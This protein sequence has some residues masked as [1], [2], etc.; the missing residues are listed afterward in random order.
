MAEVQHRTLFQVVH[1]L[2]GLIDSQLAN[3]RFWLKTEI[4]HIGS[5]SGHYYLDL[6]EH[7]DGKIIAQCSARIW[8]YSIQY[9]KQSLGEDFDNILKKGAEI[10]IYVDV[11][12]DEVYGLQ[13]VISDVDKSYALGA[14][15]KRKIETYER[16]KAEG[17]LEFNKRHKQPIVIQK[18]AVI[19][20]P[21]TSGHTDFIKQLKENEFRYL[22]QVE[23]YPCAVQ[24]EKAEGEIIEQLNKID[25]SKY[26]VV[27]VVRGGGSKLDLEVFN[28]Y[29]IAKV[30]ANYP[31]PVLTGIGHET[32][33]SIADLVA[34][35][36]YK[37]PSAVGAYIVAKSREYDVK[38]QTLY[39]HIRK[40]YEH[41]LEIQ[42]HRIQQGLLSFKTASI[43]YTQLRRGNLHTMGNRIFTEVRTAL[44]SEAKYQHSA[45]QTIDS[46]T[47]SIFQNKNSRLEEIA[48]I[49]EVKSKQ[50]TETQRRYLSHQAELLNLYAVNVLKKENETLKHTSAII[51]LYHPDKTLD[52]G[53]A[54]VRVNGNVIR[55]GLKLV[56]GDG[57]DIELIDRKIKATVISESP[58][59]SKWKT[60]ITKV[61]QKS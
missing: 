48:Q 53:Y 10:L 52:R 11:R 36:Y 25:H 41:K 40:N 57:I 6:V 19:G 38:V 14:L 5:K 3:K 13:L 46:A 60:L 43:S 56:I 29:A 47:Q 20:S 55:P 2:K 30:I 54:I 37:T 44:A 9:I 50:I 42:K 61:L 35:Q 49:C 15:E 24:G 34:N 31:V 39:H 23:N 22:Y 16:L 12:F 59:I 17:L 28:S 33:T 26:D 21:G 27:V 8:S 1:Y 45:K 51:D 7:K 4:S 18:I 32:D 58:K